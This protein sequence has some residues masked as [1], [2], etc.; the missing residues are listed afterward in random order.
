MSTERKVIEMESPKSASETPTP[1]QAY[2]ITKAKFGDEG[3]V[4][5]SQYNFRAQIATVIPT[6][7]SLQ[8]RRFPSQPINLPVEDNGLKLNLDLP[9]FQI[10]TLSSDGQ[11]PEEQ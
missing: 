4:D 6:V 8:K 5:F 1:H 11:T 3:I 10:I 7:E 2:S 9:S